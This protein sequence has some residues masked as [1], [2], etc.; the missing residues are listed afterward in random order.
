MSWDDYETVL[1]I[2]GNRPIRVTYDGDAL[3]IISPSRAHAKE[4]WLLGRFVDIL[5]EELEIPCLCLGSTTWREKR[6]NR[7]L[8][9]DD[10]FYLGADAEELC[11][12]GINLKVDPPPDLAIEIEISRS[13][14]DR[15][16]IYAALGIPELWRFNGQVLRVAR[17]QKNGAYRKAAK[18]RT[19]PF[20]PL[21]EVGR[22]VTMGTTMV[23]SRW[24]RLV[25]EWVRKD[26]VPRY[27]KH[28]ED[29]R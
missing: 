26:L 16:E 3:E 14:L 25:R 15:V 2:V 7:G 9:P 23:H 12:R 28:D 5:T 24:A 13:A 18:S 8:E 29:E 10:C 21:D 20:L 6:V 4:R 1:R 11:D 27:G 22:L 17:L 19:F